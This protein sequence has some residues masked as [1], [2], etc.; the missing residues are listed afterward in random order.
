VG[1]GRPV[2]IYVAVPDDG[3]SFVCKGGVYTYYWV[4]VDKM[5]LRCSRG[6]QG[7]SSAST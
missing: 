7:S 1:V 4:L 5:L 6:P 2:A 3:R